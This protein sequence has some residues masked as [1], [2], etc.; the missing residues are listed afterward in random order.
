M[1][2][3]SDSVCTRMLEDF[4]I[5]EEKVE[6]PEVVVFKGD[7]LPGDDSDCIGVYD[8]DKNQIS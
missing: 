5:D 8:P 1:Q 3:F 4:A 7:K 2:R 6:F